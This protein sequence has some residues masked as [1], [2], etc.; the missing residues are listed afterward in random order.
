MKVKYNVNR[1]TVTGPLYGKVYDVI[2]IER[3]WYRIIDESEEDY[4][5]PPEE[6]EI[7]EQLPSPPILTEEDILRGLGGRYVVID[8]YRDMLA[9]GEMPLELEDIPYCEIAEE[10][11]TG[12][13]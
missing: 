10:L 11:K 8:E 13:V 7:V 5:Y 1:F 4:I 2:S 12:Y 3:G 9:R 6:F